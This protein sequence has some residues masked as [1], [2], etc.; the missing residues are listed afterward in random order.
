LV[1]D[2]AEMLLQV[3]VLVVMVVLVVE[4]HTG[5]ALPEQEVL[6]PLVKEIMVL[7]VLISFLAVVVVE[8]EQVEVLVILHMLLQ[9]VQELMHTLHGQALHLL[10]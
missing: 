7:R 3:Q 8:Q 1:V 2:L 9:V 4:E 10:A 5:T 6:A